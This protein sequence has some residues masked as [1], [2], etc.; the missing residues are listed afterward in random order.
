MKDCVTDVKTYSDRVS[1][2]KIDLQG[3]DSVTV[4]NAYA[5]RFRAEDVKV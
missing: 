1:N 3:K 4:V 2:M 5:P